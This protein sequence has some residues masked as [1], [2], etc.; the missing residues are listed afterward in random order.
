MLNKA[1]TEAGNP[2]KKSPKNHIRPEK[3]LTDAILKLEPKESEEPKSIIKKN[4]GN[5]LES[6]NMRSPSKTRENL[7][8]NMSNTVVSPSTKKHHPQMSNY[9][10]FDF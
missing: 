5:Y 8:Q 1:A 4:T 10:K 6:T 7:N 3:I 9:L 2:S